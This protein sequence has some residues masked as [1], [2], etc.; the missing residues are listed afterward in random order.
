MFKL[1]GE[2]QSRRNF[3]LFGCGSHYVCMYVY[4]DRWDGSWPL[5]HQYFKYKTAAA[6]N[7]VQHIG[8]RPFLSQFLNAFV[9]L[10]PTAPVV[11]TLCKFYL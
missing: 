8:P 1:G 2:I 9:V 7:N 4:T 10:T 3:H 11:L 5:N 6:M